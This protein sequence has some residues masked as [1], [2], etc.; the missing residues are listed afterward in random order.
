MTQQEVVNRKKGAALW[1]ERAGIVLTEE[2]KR[3]IEIA[4][5]GLGKI[6]EVG[7]QAV[8]YINNERYC[9]KEMLLLPHQI[10]P[11]HRHPTRIDGSLGKQETFRCRW[12]VVYVYV[13]GDDTKCP[14][15][16][17][18][19]G[20]EQYYTSKHEIVLHPGEQ[21]T[22][23]PNTPHWFTA[24]ETGCVVSEFSSNS[25]DT[26]DIFTDVRIQRTP[27]F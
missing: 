19:L 24:G 5:F 12:G 4:D 21:F 27:K 23:L 26:T 22:M 15:A 3:N 6:D 10:C 13:P 14:K 17:P 9:G 20:D 2:E 8:T 11:E 25:E 7:L 16:K 18:P 1:Y